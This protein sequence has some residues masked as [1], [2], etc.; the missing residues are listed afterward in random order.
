LSADGRYH[1]PPQP[2]PKPDD[3]V[4]G[5]FGK[6]RTVSME[7]TY[8]EI[9]KQ[10]LTDENHRRL[11]ALSN[12]KMHKFVADA[13]AL[14]N[15]DSVFVCSDSDE[16]VKSVAR[17]AIENGE[18]HP[19]KVKGHTYHFDGYY[20]QARDKANTRY[21]VPAGMEMG[22]NINCI[23]KKRGMDEIQS[24][25]SDS[26]KGREMYVRFFSLGPTNS[27]FSI[28]AVQV[29]DSA[30]VAHSEDLLYRPG[31][32]QF[33]KLGDSPEF[34][35]VLHT[36]GELENGVSANLDQRRIYIDIEDEV[37][38][39][40]NTQYA[41]NTVGFKKLSLRLTIRKAARESW[42]AEHMFVMGVHG[43]KDRV[44]YFTGAFPSFC[45][46]TSTSMIPK[47][48]I[49]GDDIAYLRRIEGKVM[50]VNVENGV[51]GIIQDVN[52]EDDPAIWEILTTPGEVIFSNILIADGE[53][54][55]GGD[56]RE[57][58]EKGVNFSG[59]W[60]RGKK[61]KEGNRIPASHK[62]ARY[63]VQ[64]GAFPNLDLNANN[65]AGVPVGGIIYGGR[66]SDTWVPVQQS[67]NWGHGVITMGASLESET[68][69]ATL[70]QEGI[71]SFQPMSNLDFLSIPLP[72]YIEN[73]LMFGMGLEQPPVIFAVN[74]FLKDK[75]GNFLNTK[76]DKY[77][78]VKWMEERVHGEVKVRRTPTGLIP[79][80][81]DLKRLFKQV[82]KQE[83]TLEQYEEQFNLRVPE[84][85]KKIN[86]ISR[87]YGVEVDNSP[88]VLFNVLE[89][90]RHRL[91]EA[92]K[93]FGDYISPLKFA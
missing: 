80:Y 77:V 8:Q 36:A 61:D 85:L 83:F 15:P 1:S 75:E 40:V 35:C 39:T 57:L 26:M 60:F 47:E 22:A 38:Y 71:R 20:D 56:G 37:V 44:T 89:E 18:E 43:P 54:H 53:P 74:Y 81:E 11:M 21:L 59:E 30:Y 17:K 78:W 63:T 65:P 24:Y 76:K 86:R 66:D 28:S 67:F 79:L 34:F 19:L 58:P 42:L 69:A 73:H 16:D 31:Y 68:T 70:G 72:R 91:T 51:F 10:R 3:F 27:V 5:K 6:E 48:T 45:G 12:P 29:T 52:S 84:N 9:L 23:D 93:K 64:L 46:K 88:A 4:E 50:S 33:K 82:L 90:Q 41:G 87:I 92:Q 14:C 55:W 13:I 49:I 62:N 2:A 7:V 32:E 25:L